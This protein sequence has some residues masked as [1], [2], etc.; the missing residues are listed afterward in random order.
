MK[1]SDRI[2]KLI[3]FV[4]AQARLA[5]IGTDHAFVPIEVIKMGMAN[6]AIATDIGAGPLNIA[7]DNVEAAGL[8]EKIQLRLG[9]GLAPIQYEDHINTFVI[10]GMGGELI[11][12]ILA[13]AP[14]PLLKNVTLILEANNQEALV[15]QWLSDQQIQ[16]VNETI[17]FEDGHYYEFIIA[18]TRKKSMPLTQIDIQY[19]PILA[20]QQSLTFR[21]KWQHQLLIKNKILKQLT[22]SQTVPLDKVRQTELA[23]KS[24]EELLQK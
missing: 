23:I 10:A 3:D 11:R 12:Q 17:L 22:Q 2:Q 8:A 9:N 6:F 7:R 19:G 1:L 14:K 21:Q 16:I 20:R 5:D 15:R 13:T 24:I 4:P 18:D